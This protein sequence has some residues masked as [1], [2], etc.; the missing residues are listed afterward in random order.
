MTIR[1]LPATKAPKGR[2]LFL[3]GE[4]EDED[5]MKLIEVPFT[6]ASFPDV[7]KTSAT[8]MPSGS[9]VHSVHVLVEAEFDAGSLQIG[10]TGDDDAFLIVEEVSLTSIGAYGGVVLA[11]LPAAKT[12]KVTFSGAPTEGS[13]K[14]YAAYAPP[15]P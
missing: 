7:N 12:L 10:Y 11:T 3:P 1:V 2:A 9:I 6:H 5:D 13:G 4:T 14:V 8:A 15:L